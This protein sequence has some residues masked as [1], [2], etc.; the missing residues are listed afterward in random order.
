[1]KLIKDVAKELKISKSV[2]KE[3]IRNKKVS[4]EFKNGTYYVNKEDVVQKLNNTTN[5][6]CI[7]VQ[8]KLFLK[9]INITIKDFEY[10]K[11]FK[12]QVTIK[13]L[14]NELSSINKTRT[15]HLLNT[16]ELY[17]Y[18]E[19]CLQHTDYTPVPQMEAEHQYMFDFLSKY[20]VKESIGSSD[21]F[22]YSYIN[23]AQ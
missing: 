2:I 5:N 11:H 7:K 1:M 19:W 20:F 4:Y 9:C 12:K 16:V 22:M 13:L 6:N 18:L 15:I 17:K 14:L 23:G 10:R 3:M 21:G 8:D